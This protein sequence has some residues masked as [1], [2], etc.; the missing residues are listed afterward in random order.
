M[1]PSTTPFWGTIYSQPSPCGHLYLSVTCIK[2]SRFSCPVIPN[3][4]WIEPLLWAKLSYQ[5]TFS[6]SQS[7][8]LYTGLI[9]YIY[10]YICIVKPVLRGH[11]WNKYKVI[12]SDRCLIEVTAWAGLTVYPQWRCMLFIMRQNSNN[13]DFYRSKL[14]MFSLTSILNS[15]ACMCAWAINIDTISG[16]VVVVIVW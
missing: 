15:P 2:R 5:A 13:I 12:F 8:P 16:A 10:I 7:W 6:F 14:L 3:L 1:W 11:L 9:I 4:M